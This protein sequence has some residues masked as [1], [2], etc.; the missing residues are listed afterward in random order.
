MNKI[1][2][3]SIA[4]GLV[5]LIDAGLNLTAPE[6]LPRSQLPIDPALDPNIMCAALHKSRIGF[7]F[8]YAHYGA[9]GL[10]TNNLVVALNWTIVGLLFVVMAVT[11]WRG[12]AKT[13]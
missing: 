7:P 4:A 11:Y 10:E 5:A 1:R 9:C 8:D 6:W 3:F 13:K 12:K 2:T